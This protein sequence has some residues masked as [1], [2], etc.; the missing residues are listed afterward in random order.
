MMYLLIVVLWILCT[1][2][3]NAMDDCPELGRAKK[4]R[5]GLP[6]RANTSMTCAYRNGINRS[7]RKSSMF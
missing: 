3:H 7:A 5:N 2:H 1:G 6:Y 4:G